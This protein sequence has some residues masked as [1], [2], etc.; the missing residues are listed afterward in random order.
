MRR[1]R[2]TSPRIT[3]G[4]GFT[5]PI[6]RVRTARGEDAFS[7]VPFVYRERLGSTI[8]HTQTALL[9]VE[10]RYEEGSRIR[11]NVSND[12]LRTEIEAGRSTA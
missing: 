7:W 4:R 5:F 8:T 9:R 2:H 1:C 3:L 10:D 6:R 11:G 12:T